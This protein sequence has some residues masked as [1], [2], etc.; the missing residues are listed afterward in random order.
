MAHKFS[1]ERQ[2]IIHNNMI[3]GLI[4]N[5]YELFDIDKHYEQSI[6]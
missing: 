3:F 1:K 2:I 6:S 4:I 5:I